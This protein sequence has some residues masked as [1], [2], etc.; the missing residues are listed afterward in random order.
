MS[1]SNRNKTER[2][3]KATRNSDLA[4]SGSNSNQELRLEKTNV[5]TCKKSFIISIWS[6]EGAS[7]VM[8]MHVIGSCKGHIGW[9]TLLYPRPP[10]FE[11]LQDYIALILTQSKSKTTITR[12]MCVISLIIFTDDDQRTRSAFYTPTVGFAHRGKMK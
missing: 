6:W 1:L 4:S 3:M 9:H 2:P 5:E 10:L 12:S 11:V 7:G 8:I